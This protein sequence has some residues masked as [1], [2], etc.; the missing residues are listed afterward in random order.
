MPWKASEEEEEERGLTAMAAG[1][2]S[3]ETRRD[4][5]RGRARSGADA[6]SSVPPAAAGL[7]GEGEGEGE[8]DGGDG[9]I[10]AA[11]WLAGDWL[12]AIGYWPC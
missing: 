6:L 5:K 1:V 11:G 8:Q 2:P 7:Q 12:L 4:E 9:W 3:A 10:Y